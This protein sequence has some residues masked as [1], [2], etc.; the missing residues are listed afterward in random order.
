SPGR[1]PLHGQ[2]RPLRELRGDQALDEPL[3]DGQLIRVHLR[4]AH[5]GHSSVASRRTSIGFPRRCSGGAGMISEPPSR[6]IAPDGSRNE[7]GHPRTA[8]G[9]VHQ[10]CSGGA[11]GTRTRDP[12]TASVVRYQ[13]RHS[14]LLVVIPYST[15]LSVISPGASKCA[16]AASGAIATCACRAPLCRG[17]IRGG[18]DGRGGFAPRRR[19]TAITTA[20][21]S[22]AR[23]AA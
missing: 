2:V 18:D 11:D 14:P 13:L 16:E 17:G 21:A 6:Q 9:L 20:G 3:V 12:H 8:D 5:R 4:R 7:K 10:A 22:V 15:P 19:P 1:N 23:R